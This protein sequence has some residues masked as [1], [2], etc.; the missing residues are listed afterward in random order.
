MDLPKRKP[1]RLKNYDYSQ[2]GGYF[3]TV[4]IRNKRRIL[5]RI[6]GEGSPL[7]KLTAYGQ[8]VDKYIKM[9]DSRYPEITV[10]KYV[11]MPN[12]IHILAQI[13]KEPFGTGDPSPTM[14]A[15]IAWMKYQ[16]TKEINLMRNSPG[17][18]IWQR[19]FHDHIIRGTQD[20]EEIWQYIDEN[21]LRWKTDCFY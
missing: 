11:I 13:Y 14:D 16:T 21:P 17:D 10:E 8:I 7:P 3:I 12:H 1:T 20:Y 2:N 19:S 15:A 9:I 6:V 5:S 4:C 18:K